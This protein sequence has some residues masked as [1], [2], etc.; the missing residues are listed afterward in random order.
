MTLGISQTTFTF[1][2]SNSQQRSDGSTQIIVNPQLLYSS[3]DLM[4]IQQS[5]QIRFLIGSDSYTM[6][7]DHFYQTKGFVDDHGTA[8]ELPHKMFKIYDDSGKFASFSVTPGGFKISYSDD[9]TNHYKIMPDD[10]GD[11]I[12]EN[13]CGLEPIQYYP[14]RFLTV[15]ISTDQYYRDIHE[16]LADDVISDL[17]YFADKV[18]FQADITIC[19]YYVV[20]TSI[21][22]DLVDDKKA[23][24]DWVGAFWKEI[25]VPMDVCTHVTGANTPVGGSSGSGNSYCNTLQNSNEYTASYSEQRLTKGY[26][27]YLHF[28]HELTHNLGVGHNNEA[29]S[30]PNGSFYYMYP[31][32]I[33]SI[34]A[35]YTKYL[36]LED[37][38][39]A[40]QEH[41]DN[42]PCPE[43]C[44]PDTSCKRCE[45][46]VTLESNGQMAET[47]D[48]L[49]LFLSDD[50][51]GEPV[52]NYDF[53]FTIENGCTPRENVG[54]T[55]TA[56]NGQSEFSA[57]PTEFTKYINGFG[58]M[59]LT[60]TI[61]MAANEVK[62]YN[63]SV[64][65]NDLMAT[66]TAVRYSLTNVTENGNSISGNI[67]MQQLQTISG[68]KHW[69]DLPYPIQLGLNGNQKY[70]VRLDGTLYLD[71]TNINWHNNNI[72][73]ASPESKI[74]VTRYTPGDSHSIININTTK[75]ETCGDFMWRGIEASYDTELKIR[76]CVIND[77]VVGVKLRESYNN[78]NGVPSTRL[79]VE[80]TEFKNNFIGMNIEGHPNN[81]DLTVMPLKNVK[82]T[83]DRDLYGYPYSDYDDIGYD[84]GVSRTLFGIKAKNQP[85]ISLAYND[86]A[87]EGEEMY[88]VFSGVK[89]GILLDHTNLVSDAALFS[90]LAH[91]TVDVIPGYEYPELGYGIKA[92]NG[93]SIVLDGDNA[94]TFKNL[95][96]GVWADNSAV[97]VYKADFSEI[98]KDAIT[99]KNV[100]NMPIRIGDNTMVLKSNS[101]NGIV[102]DNNN[103][104]ADAV[105]R[106]NDITLYG[107]GQQGIR[108]SEL[109]PVTAYEVTANNLTISGTG[110]RG[111][112]AVSGGNNAFSD[113]QIT[114][115]P[116]SQDVYNWCIKDDGSHAN[117]YQCNALYGSTNPESRPIYGLS[118]RNSSEANVQCNSIY[119]NTYGLQF[120]GMGL[121]ADIRGNAFLYSN[122]GLYYG[123][124]PSQGDA[125][126]G[127]QRH[128]GNTWANGTFADE[129]AEH[130]SQLQSIVDKSLYLVDPSIN[131]N[132]STQ[133][134]AVIDWI[135]NDNGNGTTYSCIQ[136]GIDLCGSN[137]NGGTGTGSNYSGGSLGSSLAAGIA[138]GNIY[139]GSYPQ[140]LN[141]TADQQLYA[142]LMGSGVPPAQMAAVY[143]SF[144][145]ANQN[146]T[147]GDLYTYGTSVNDI[148]SSTNMAQVMTDH[149]DLSNALLSYVQTYAT[150]DSITLVGMVDAIRAL[151]A[152]AHKSDSLGR[153]YK[154]DRLS[155]L[156]AIAGN[157]TTSN[158]LSEYQYSTL[159]MVSK[160]LSQTALSSSEISELV[161]LAES[162]PLAAGAA[163]YQARALLNVSEVAYDDEDE[164]LCT[165]PQTRISGTADS[166]AS[167]GVAIYPNPATEQ[168][169]IDGLTRPCR[170]RISD[171]KGAIVHEVHYKAEHSTTTELNTGQWTPGVYQVKIV[172]D[173]DN[174]QENHRLIIVR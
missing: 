103:T 99:V 87:E 8:I 35:D 130:L 36:L 115:E 54:I 125:F 82:F 88:N 102:L 79:T 75:F 42:K 127:E 4:A 3:I 40:I 97:D 57:Y 28:V 51:S 77:A 19:F 20:N 10:Q 1:D 17:V 9:Q 16:E 106:A 135:R 153:V 44:N 167:T 121:D 56:L 7:N 150:S 131:Q 107:S 25:C 32:S 61:N 27:D 84:P 47:G 39:V 93:S 52:T 46:I 64:S 11:Y 37:E 78:P 129:G 70:T 104:T 119:G 171:T 155:Q 151:H 170:I 160:V 152:D 12:V 21:D 142:A 73:V 69:F 116:H 133:E 96:Y 95:R 174:S 34:N 134:T 30:L 23:F 145:A 89:N 13:R 62:T 163:T 91:T 123:L 159:G 140:A 173:G 136:N 90:D 169:V 55:F 22:S 154:L 81:Q 165:S 137:G 38:K 109:L 31:Y 168:V 114:I 76:D 143:Q 18:L 14:S 105:I 2:F 122:T 67:V 138:S 26:P 172:Y 58:N 80:N 146:S 68:I 100:D 157:R 50:C 29:N 59:E 128:H 24:R 164:S 6:Q 53:T 101:S 144:I 132:L 65:I 108:I 161:S 5:D 15:G 86:A 124:Y 139:T 45:P 156:S 92:I 74:V 83:C 43:N 85:L 149:V 113:N 41:Y 66:S 98:Y 112:W 126:S 166:S 60:T 94:H 162:C 72:L 147:I 48:N 120:W 110:N 148:Y 118:L 33:G 71:N 63:F 117:S 158:T 111:I 141:F 49:F